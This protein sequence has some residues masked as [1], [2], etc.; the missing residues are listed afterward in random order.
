MGGAAAEEEDDSDHD[1]AEDADDLER[2][3]PELGFSV[4]GDRNHVEE[5][6]NDEDDGDPYTDVHGL[7][8]VFDYERRGGNFGSDNCGG[9][10]GACRG[11]RSTWGDLRI[12]YAY[13]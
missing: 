10:L 13:Q 7:R 12:A 9:L 5:E 2:G 4:V 6:T 1:E 3:E 11:S 8:P